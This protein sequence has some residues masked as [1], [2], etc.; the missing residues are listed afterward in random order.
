MSI[1]HICRVIGADPSAG[2]ACI[3]KHVF[4]PIWGRPVTT[5]DRSARDSD[6]QECLSW[7]GGRPKTKGAMLR[8]A[9]VAVER[10]SPSQE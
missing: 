3:N 4:L 10:Q 8:P 7:W 9:K 6:L 1:S 5:G 2:L